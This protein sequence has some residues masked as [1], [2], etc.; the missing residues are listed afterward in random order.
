MQ[1]WTY[2]AKFGEGR[3]MRMTVAPE[4]LVEEVDVKQQLGDCVLVQ[5]WD[6]SASE[7]VL[8][9]ERISKRVPPQVIRREHTR[10]QLAM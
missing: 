10:K 4:L 6:V 8:V 9:Y 3:A 1:D 7:E 2:R 5:H